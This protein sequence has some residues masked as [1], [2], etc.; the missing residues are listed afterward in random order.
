MAKF[1]Q[2]NVKYL[3]GKVQQTEQNSLIT[4]LKPLVSQFLN[5]S[6][7]FIIMFLQFSFKILLY[8]LFQFVLSQQSAVDVRKIIEI[9]L[10]APAALILIQL[11]I[12][13][14]TC[15]TVPFSAI[16]FFFLHKCFLTTIFQ[17]PHLSSIS[18]FD[19]AFT[20]I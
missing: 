7:L 2:K 14:K 5:Y 15:G 9:R 4:F 13:F 10:S 11:L 18:C 1:F 12:C 6:A 17:I 8:P 3:C 19:K 16:K 20:Q